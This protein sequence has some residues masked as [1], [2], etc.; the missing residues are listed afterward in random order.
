MSWYRLSKAVCPT[1]KELLERLAMVRAQTVRAQ[2]ARILWWDYLSYRESKSEDWR[3]G[4]AQ[5][6]QYTRKEVP[7]DQLEQ[8]L[9]LVG[10][11]RDVAR[12]RVRQ[13]A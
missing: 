2:V 12:K 1:E 11:A 8:A 6:L 3:G 7:Q 9:V 13:V 4:W 10:Y 5:W